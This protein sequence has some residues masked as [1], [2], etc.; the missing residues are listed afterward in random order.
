[1]FWILGYYIYKKR[2]KEW[3][4]IGVETHIWSKYN[5]LEW[6][7]PAY[8]GRL[9][10][11]RCLSANN[12]GRYP[13]QGMHRPGQGRYPAAMVGT[14]PRQ[15]RSAQRIIAAWRA[16]CLLRSRRRTFLLCMNAWILLTYF[17]HQ[18]MSDHTSGCGSSSTCTNTE[19]SYTCACLNGLKWMTVAA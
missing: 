8:G 16:I 10:F 9:C 4:K 13:G 11:Y 15:D 18:W 12:G 5:G 17:R 7:P 14:P 2:S 19:G 3:I 1:M 6:L